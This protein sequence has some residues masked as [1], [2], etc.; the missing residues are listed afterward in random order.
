MTSSAE[1]ARSLRKKPAYV[2]G[3][4]TAHDHAMMISQMPDLC[5]TAGAISGPKAFKM[6]GI[7]P[8]DVD[9]VEIYDSF[10]IT[11]ALALEAPV[12]GDLIKD[13][14]LH[15]DELNALL[16][17]RPIVLVGMMGAG[18]TTLFRLIR[19]EHALDGGAISLPSRARI[20]GVEP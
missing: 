6:A 11:V 16:A 18:K 8:R 5:T 14:A 1:R 13:P 15:K 10:T 17:G 19:G 4:G 20:G 9:V 2:L 7:T 3:A 12:T